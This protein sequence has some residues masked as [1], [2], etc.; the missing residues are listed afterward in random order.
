VNG[1]V[2]GL[3]VAVCSGSDGAVVAAQDGEREAGGGGDVAVR[4]ARVAV[5][6]DLELLGLHRLAEAVQAA[7]ARVPAPAEDQLARAAGADQLV[8][9]DVRA[10]SARA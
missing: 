7:D 1:Q 8:V 6:L 10:S 4:H 3:I 2:I 9:D 5:L